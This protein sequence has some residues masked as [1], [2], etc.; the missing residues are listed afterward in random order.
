MEPAEQE[1]AARPQADRARRVHGHRHPEVHAGGGEVEVRRHDAPHL[2]GDPVERQRPPD[3]GRVGA[4][5]LAPQRVAQQGGPGGAGALVVESEAR[6]QCRRPAETGEQVAGDRRDVDAQGLVE[7][8]QRPVVRRD[9]RGDVEGARPFAQLDELADVAD[10]EYADQPVRLG[11]RQRPQENAVQGAEDGGGRADGEGQGGDRHR[12]E[13]GAAGEGACAAPYVLPK[14]IEPAPA[15]EVPDV[16]ADE[17]GRCRASPAPPARRRR[18]TCPA[19]CSAASRAPGAG[20]AR[21][22]CRSPPASRVGGGATATGGRAVCAA[23][24]LVSSG[25]FR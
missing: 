20:R 4:E 21:A 7:A 22:G 2:V 18:A 6:T 9:V 12:R 3:D 24:S 10:V 15:P 1:R 14:L 23:A 16:L 19:R 17:P 11:D 5:T 8:G 13:P 25:I